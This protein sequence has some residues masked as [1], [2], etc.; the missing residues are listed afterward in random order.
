VID[1]VR[2]AVTQ[3]RLRHVRG[4]SRFISR[5]R[6]SRALL[7]PL[8][9]FGSSLSPSLFLSLESL[10]EEGTSSRPRKKL[11]MKT[12]FRRADVCSPNLPARG[13]LG[14]ALRR[15]RRREF[16]VGKR[17]KRGKRGR[18]RHA[19]W[20]HSLLATSGTFVVTLI[21]RV[22]IPLSYLARVRR[23]RSFICRTIDSPVYYL[24]K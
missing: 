4:F 11:P 7:H 3:F 10:V 6:V 8:I 1:N 22:T 20:K 14:I 24:H 21:A 15:A 5:A 18:G 2:F 9:P 12:E 17:I 13:L 19:S 23:N 16:R